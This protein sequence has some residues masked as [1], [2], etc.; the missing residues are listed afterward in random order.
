M[1]RIVLEIVGTEMANWG[2]LCEEH[3]N[4]GVVLK[5]GMVVHL[6]KLHLLVEGREEGI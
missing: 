4:C 6:G 1:P 5:E 3:T 2:R